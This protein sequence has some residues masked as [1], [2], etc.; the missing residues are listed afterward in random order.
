[1][2][3][4]RRTRALHMKPK[5][6]P[7]PLSPEI[8]TNRISAVVPRIVDPLR[9]TSGVR[10]AVRSPLPSTAAPP[11]PLPARRP[12]DLADLIDDEPD[13]A[14]EM[15]TAVESVSAQLMS[16]VRED[17][18]DH[19]YDP[20][21]KE[22][23]VDTQAVLRAVAAEGLPSP[24]LPDIERI[25]DLDAIEGLEID[26]ETPDAAPPMSREMP[27][28]FARPNPLPP[29]ERTPRMNQ[30]LVAP[31]PV[32]VRTVAPPP[33]SVRPLAAPPPSVR[34]PMPSRPS[35]LTPPPMAR[36]VTMPPFPAMRPPELGIAAPSAPAAFAPLPVLGPGLVPPPSSSFR[37]AMPSS[38][39][40]P[41]GPPSSPTFL[42]TVPASRRSF[43]QSMT[44]PHLPHPVAR[45]AYHR[46]YDDAPRPSTLKRALVLVGVSIAI[47][48]TVVTLAHVITDGTIWS[49]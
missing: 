15:V 5:A 32:P 13:A 24:V 45:R 43:E 31:P 28:M 39:S 12:E 36:P 16:A 26:E 9:P 41:A 44:G 22:T 37:A 1:M 29:V 19:H 3:P 40:L 11:R 20:P 23:P 49:F 46:D 38:S 10:A 25:E 48:A 7:T 42:T 34:P 21:T 17:S 47:V 30:P 4:G 2:L 27:S 18:I 35:G 6:S 8:R 33:P 14:H